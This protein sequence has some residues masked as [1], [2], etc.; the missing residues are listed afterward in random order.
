M[1]IALI[2]GLLGE[3]FKTTGFVRWLV[4]G[5]HPAVGPFHVKAQGT[6]GACFVTSTRGRCCPRGCVLAA[7]HDL[8]P[9]A[10]INSHRL[11]PNSLHSPSSF[12]PYSYWARHITVLTQELEVP[13]D[14]SQ[15]IFSDY[16][17]HFL[18]VRFLLQESQAIA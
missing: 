6:W 4:R 10:S 11:A 14:P 3:V 18:P 17:G 7:P 12:G 15:V 1:I 9:P 13:S 16:P 5:A 8:S 2:T